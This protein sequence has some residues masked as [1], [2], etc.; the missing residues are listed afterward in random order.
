[1]LLLLRWASGLKLAR[2]LMVGMIGLATDATLF[3]LLAEGGHAEFLARA[4]SLGAATLV[5]WRLN[6]LF[7]FGPSGRHSGIESARYA[8]VALGAQL[9]SYLVFLLLRAAVPDGPALAALLSGAVF[10]AGISFLGQRFFTFAAVR[11]ARSR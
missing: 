8:G 6:R 5:T 4:I 3:S 9:L 7:T 10:A 11:P 2:F 1:V